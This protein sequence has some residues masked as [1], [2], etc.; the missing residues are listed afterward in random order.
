VK[1]SRLTTNQTITKHDRCNLSRHN[2]SHPQTHLKNI[3][4]LN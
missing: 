3:Q 1:L 4:S 2:S